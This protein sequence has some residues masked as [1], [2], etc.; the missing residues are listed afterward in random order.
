MHSVRNGIIALI[1]HMTSNLEE[2][3]L[4][5]IRKVTLIFVCGKERL[6]AMVL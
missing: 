6:A 1:S 3:K 4:A 2:S 5:M